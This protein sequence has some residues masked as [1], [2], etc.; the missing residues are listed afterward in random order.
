MGPLR[1]AQSSTI[2][3]A[4]CDTKLYCSRCRS[5]PTNISSISL[6]CKLVSLTRCGNASVGTSP[7]QN[8]TGVSNLKQHLERKHPAE[9]R[10]ARKKSTHEQQKSLCKRLCCP[11]FISIQLWLSYV[12]HCLRPFAVVQNEDVQTHISFERV[13]LKT[14]KLYV[15]AQTSRVD[16]NILNCAPGRFSLVFVEKPLRKRIMW[17][18]L[19]CFQI[20]TH[21][22]T[23]P[24]AWHCRH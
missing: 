2:C 19:Q 17:H 6:T 3:S 10:T 5:Y 9:L 16:D 22:V 1:V 11:K 8:G 20:R 12:T 23:A 7:T 21:M 18:F 4:N 24:R 13:S 14:F 15:S